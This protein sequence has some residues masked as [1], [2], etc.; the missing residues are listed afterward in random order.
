MLML[1]A[2]S[3]LQELAEMVEI[4]ITGPEEEVKILEESLGAFN[5]VPYYEL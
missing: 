1:M 2:A 4:Q 3:V 5:P